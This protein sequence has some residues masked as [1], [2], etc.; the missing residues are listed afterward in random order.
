MINNTTEESRIQPLENFF[1]N[2]QNTL[3][4]DLP[5][6]VGADRIIQR[7]FEELNRYA[8][9]IEELMN[10]DSV[11]MKQSANKSVIEGAKAEGKAEGIVEG[12]S[13]GG[14]KKA[15]NIA[16]NLLKINMPIEDIA[17]FTELTVPEIKELQKT[18]E[19]GYTSEVLL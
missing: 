10:Y 16:I 11:D 3:E 18:I 6:I 8:W 9:S 7:A 2:A 15:K 4:Q 1:K 12:E 19:Y 13:R 17:K 5:A 14:V